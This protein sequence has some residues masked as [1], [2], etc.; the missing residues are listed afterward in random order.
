[1][2]QEIQKVHIDNLEFGKRTK[3][4]KKFVECFPKQNPVHITLSVEVIEKFM[5]CRD[6]SLIGLE[7][8]EIIEIFMEIGRRS[9]VTSVDIT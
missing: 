5:G 9:N 6:I 2:H 1:M 7:V 8:E 4:Y 3:G